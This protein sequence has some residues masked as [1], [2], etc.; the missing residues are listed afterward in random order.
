LGVECTEAE[1]AA[2]AQLRID[3]EVAPLV[4]ETLATSGG[5]G[6]ENVIKGLEHNPPFYR[7]IVDGRPARRVDA[8]WRLMR[9]VVFGL[10]MASVPDW[11]FAADF[12]RFTLSLGRAEIRGSGAASRSMF[13][14]QISD[15]DEGEHRSLGIDFALGDE[16]SLGVKYERADLEYESPLGGLC[17]PV[18]GILLGYEFCR[19]Q[20]TSRVGSIEDEFSSVVISVTRRWRISERYTALGSAGYKRS[21][22]SSP[23]DIEAETYSTCRRFYGFDTLISGCNPLPN[24]ATVSGLVGRL[25]GSVAF[26]DAFELELGANWEQE[27]YRIFRNDAAPR[28]CAQNELSGFGGFCPSLEAF[29]PDS[30]FDD[31]DWYWWSSSFSWRPGEGPWSFVLRAEEGGTRDWRVLSGEVR[32]HW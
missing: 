4:V 6:V 30:A 14:K 19:P 16:W 22:W 5:A 3:P 11:T 7:P 25:A 8:L 32:Y 2:L 1:R 20:S 29:L 24:E 13:D 9:P 28:F 27:R 23:Q 31:D 10:T 26:G 15:I 21:E 12:E 17:Q 18:A